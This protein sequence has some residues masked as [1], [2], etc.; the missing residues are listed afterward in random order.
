[1]NA[2]DTTIFRSVQ[3]LAANDENSNINFET[4]MNMELGNI[5]NWITGNKL[6]LNV[7]KSKYMIYSKSN[8]L[9][10]YP[11]IKIDDSI[12]QQVHQFNFLGIAFDDYLNCKLHIE[13]CALKC[14]RNIGM[15]NKLK[16][17]PPTT[18]MLT[19]YHTL[20][21]SHLCYDIMVWGHHC[22]ILITIQKKS[23]NSC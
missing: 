12:I 9:N 21:H 5:G 22:D 4:E 18:M 10:S 13:R 17:F 16:R 6:S 3:S 23:F 8:K 1:M 11:E 7:H 19:L 20:I 14:S 2:D 15:V